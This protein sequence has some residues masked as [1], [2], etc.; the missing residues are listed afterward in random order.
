MTQT[1]RVTVTVKQVLLVLVEAETKE[2][3]AELANDGA[4]VM[5]DVLFEEYSDARDV[6]V[7]VI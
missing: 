6:E 2:E 4:Y 3:A 1:Y 7:D 5:E